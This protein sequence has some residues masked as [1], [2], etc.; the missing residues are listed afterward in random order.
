[1]TCEQGTFLLGGAEDSTP[2]SS[3]DIHPSSPSNGIPTPAAS[4]EAEPR[5]DG[6]QGCGCMRETPGC[7][8]HPNT[9][10][11][12]IASMQA[13]LAKIFQQPVKVL[14]S[15]AN[16]PDFIG[17]SCDAPMLYDPLTYSWK[18]AQQSLVEDLGKFS[19]TWPTAGMMQ[20]G[21][22]WPLPRLV[23]R[24]NAIDGGAL[25]PTPRASDW[26]K[27]GPNQMQGGKPAL[28]NIAAKWPTP[29]ASLGRGSG[30]PSPKTA[31]ARYAQGKRF[32]DDAVALWPTPTA[33]DWKSGSHGNQGNSRPLSETVGGSLN[34]TWVAW[35]QAWPLEATKLNVSE[36]DKFLCARRRRGKS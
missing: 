20:G 8:T 34:P 11:V 18:T 15:T 2:T 1:M 9:P 27:G 28:A 10:A 26:E 23:P 3:L 14:E 19:G 36:T 30:M 32:L 6:F 21:R 31:A 22:S 25:L 35:L 29:T 17:R 33:R 24:I 5:M 13:S 16:A 12:W 4:C 7:S